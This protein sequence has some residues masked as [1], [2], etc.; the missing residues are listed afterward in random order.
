MGVAVLMATYGRDDP[1]FLAEALESLLRQ[2][3][4]P[5]EVVL[6]E[7][8][9]LPLSL[10]EVIETYRRQLPLCSVALV[11]NSGLAA[12]LNAGLARCT[13]AWVARFDSDDVAEPQRIE[14]QLAAA[15]Q[16]LADVFGGYA[17]EIGA[18]GMPGEVRRMPL[19]HGAIMASLWA[20]PF[21]HPTVM[22]RREAIVAL[23]GYRSDL[24]R[25]E[26]YDLWFR[27]ARAG[28]RFANLPEVLIR[29][30]FDAASHGR[31]SLG[32]ALE[33]AV[34]GFRGAGLVGLPLWTRFACFVPVLRSLLPLGLRHGA[35]TW[36]SRFDPRRKRR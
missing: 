9:P 28:L 4:L 17:L 29:H 12:A 30:R 27:C 19:D 5:E 11:R 24:R 10:R 18:D 13:Q 22:Y 33:R 34:T 1:V 15:R 35:Y 23:G 3:H 14:L 20:C 26:D 25:S 36:L 6:V 31:H 16:G 8:G 2:T 32:D 21:I 7:D